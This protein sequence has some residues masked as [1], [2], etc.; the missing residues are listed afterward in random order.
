MHHNKIQSKHTITDFLSQLTL[1]NYR[2]HDSRIIKNKVGKQAI[3]HWLEF[4]RFHGRDSTTGSFMKLLYTL[5]P[6]TSITAVHSTLSIGDWGG[7]LES[8]TCTERKSS[9]THLLEYKGYS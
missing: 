9:Q 6:G 3:A 5:C 8:N 7:L 4:S 1:G 2:Y